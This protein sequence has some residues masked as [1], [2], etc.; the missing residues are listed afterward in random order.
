MRMKFTRREILK[1]FGSIIGMVS[2]GKIALAKQKPLKKVT[3]DSQ[4]TVYRAINGNPETNLNKVIELLGGI[5]AVIGSDDVVVIKQNVQ[6]WNQGAPNLL[7]L[8]TFV[9][10]IMERP[11]GFRGE[12][13]VAENCHRGSMPWKRAGWVTTFSRNSGLQGIKNMNGLSGHL[14]GKYD[15]RFSTCHWI[16]VGSGGRR[17]FGPAD[18]NGYVYCDGTGGIPLIKFSNGATGD[19]FRSVIMTYPIF[20]TDKGTVIDFKNGIWEKDAYTE[21]P[22][23]FINFAA[24]NH[25]STYCGA[26]SAIKN[27]LGVSDLSGGPDPHNGGLLTG[28]YYNFHSFPFNKWAPGPQPGMIGA[29]I[30]VFLGKIRKADL[31]ITTAQWVGLASRTDPPVARTHAVLASKDP[32]ALD[33]HATKYLLYPNSRASIHNPDD[34]KSPLHQ[35]LLGCA[36]EGG[37][38]FDEKYVEVKSYDFEKKGIQ[39]DNDLVVV[40][41]K[42]WGHQPQTI[43]KYLL[44]RYV[45][46][47]P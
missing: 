4:V 36:E 3:V 12:V 5:E 31:N 18:G 32:I 43:L 26:T 25:H 19:D 1:I 17:V 22:L 2:F 44:L 27:Y 14:K 46:F 45:S 39:G 11:G 30:G 33:Y 42:E 6:W 16:D 9:D 15:D 20:K 24:L 10:L 37:G 21:Q 35:Y 7:A 8:K 38:I 41:E 47:L 13:V 29:E 40:G 23:K 28:Q 34:K